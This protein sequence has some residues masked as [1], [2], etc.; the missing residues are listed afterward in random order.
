MNRNDF[1]TLMGNPVPPD[2]QVITELFELTK[3]FPYFQTAHLL[4]LKGLQASHDVK[5]EDQL[6]KSAVYVADREVLYDHLQLRDVSETNAEQTVPVILPDLSVDEQV[7]S[8]NKISDVTASDTNLPP[9]PSIE[10]SVSKDDI[11]LQEEESAKP[12]S[13]NENDQTVIENARNSN[14]LIADKGNLNTEG[15]E[16]HTLLV[17]IDNE[18]TPDVMVLSGDDLPGDEEQVFFTDPGTPASE[19]IDLLELDT[20]EEE[21]IA[22]QQGSE[23]KEIHHIPPSELID[24]F[25]IA[26]PRIEP[27]KEKKD[28]PEDDRSKPAFEEGGFVTETLARIYTAQGYYSKAIDIYE[29]LSLKFPE[30]SSYFATQIEKVKEYLKN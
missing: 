13:D 23:E 18:E 29:K 16:S 14:A 20:E 26:N 8:G 1:L 4:L 22:P 27:N 28:F 11:H 2:K 3:I 24:R 19:K 25:I 7:N 30:K 5:F 12:T 17:D 15:Q 10:N 6:R 9:E 21:N